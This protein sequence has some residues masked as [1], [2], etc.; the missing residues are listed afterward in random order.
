MTK[1]YNT[2]TNNWY[3]RKKFDAGSRTASEQ[4][5]SKNNN[6]MPDIY[7]NFSK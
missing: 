4:T 5:F 7:S 3:G 1:G 6:K 2:I